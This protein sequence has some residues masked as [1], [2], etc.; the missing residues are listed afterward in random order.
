[1]LRV[2]IASIAAFIVSILVTP[3]T[4]KLAMKLGVYDEPDARKVHTGLMTR[5]GGL[6]IYVGFI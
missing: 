5:M 4:K 1:M 2:I 6:G 3:Q